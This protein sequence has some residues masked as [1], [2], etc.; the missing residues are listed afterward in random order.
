MQSNSKLKMQLILSIL[1]ITMTILGYYKDFSYMWEYC[2]LSGITVGIIYLLSFIFSTF[3][4]K[5]FPEWIH[6]ACM[7]NIL[8]ILVATILMQLSL[9]GAFWFIHIINPCLL[10]IF[11]LISSDHSKIKKLTFVV[12]PLIFPLSYI[13][14]SF[15]RYQLTGL[16]AFPADMILVGWGTPWIPLLIIL[17]LSIVIIV[18]SIGLHYLNCYLHKLLH[19]KK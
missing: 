5:N 15:I 7:V 2:F 16:C 3:F 6:F 19:L 14:I 9:D 12:T 8:I 1:F 10:F 17:G 4:H 11:W 18:F 13:G